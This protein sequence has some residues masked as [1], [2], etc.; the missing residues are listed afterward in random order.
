MKQYRV[1]LVSGYVHCVADEF[2][3]RMDAV[4]SDAGL[5]GPGQGWRQRKGGGILGSSGHHL[6]SGTNL[7][8][9][10]QTWVFMV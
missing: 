7:R 2:S 5:R 4:D 6:S 1:G 8:G 10:Q 3:I 9:K